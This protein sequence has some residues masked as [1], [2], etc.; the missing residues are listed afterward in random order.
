MN[1]EPTSPKVFISHASEDK[2]RFVEGFARRLRD[3]GIDAWLDVWEIAPGDDLPK[4][5]FEEGLG[6]ASCVIVVL[7]PAFVT[8][9]WPNHE[10]SASIIQ[11][12]YGN[13]K[14]IP[15][16]I[17]GCEVPK[18]L[19]STLW[20]KINDLSNY[21]REFKRIVNA[22]LARSERPPLGRISPSKPLQIDSF[23]GLNNV[24]TL[25][26]KRACELTLAS[27]SA[28]V[29]SSAIEEITRELSLVEEDVIESLEILEDRHMI[30][31]SWAM[32]GALPTFRI[33][34]HGFENYARF[35][36]PGFSAFVDEALVILVN[37]ALKTGMSLAKFMHQNL[38]L[39]E[40]VLDIL[41]E[42]KLVQLVRSHGTNEGTGIL[43]VLPQGRRR[44]AQVSK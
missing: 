15:V 9:P 23:P 12:I 43:Q 28:W 19:Q 35:C 26:L 10:L 44:A 4:K 36:I 3:N 7:S 34:T 14:I 42:R 11:R 40:Y 20:E 18:S 17:E 21:D 5:V 27:G 6:A 33:T 13:L 39:I 38:V 30:K 32:D 24:D 41:E 8:K 22:I 25:L 2:Q 37:H 16:V 31:A 29:D 1:P